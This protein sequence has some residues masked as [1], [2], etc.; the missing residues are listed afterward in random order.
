MK[1]LLSC[2]SAS[3]LAL[4]LSA[5]GGGDDDPPIQPETDPDM[6]TLPSTPDEPA[7]VPPTTM[8]D[9]PVDPEIPLP[10]DVI[11]AADDTPSPVRFELSWRS[12]GTTGTRAVQCAEMQVPLDYDNPDGE[13]ILI[14]LNRILAPSDVEHHG[15]LLYNPGGPGGSGKELARGIAGIGGFDSIAPG[16]DIIGFDPR[17][18]GDSSALEC[19]FIDAFLAGETGEEPPEDT[20][21]EMASE[22]GLEAL[23]EDWA[24]LSE[25]CRGYW[26][27]LFDH[28]GSNDVVRDIDAIRAALGEEKL[29][30]FGASYGTR[31]GALYAQTYPERVRAIVLDAPVSPRTSIV[32]HV[33]SQ[34]DETL[35]VQEAF[36]TECEAG[37]YTCPP[38][39]RALFE[40]LVTAA[41]ALGVLSPIIS[42]WELGLAY[43]SYRSYL[44]YLLEQQATQPNSDWI[45]SE[46]GRFGN[47]NGGFIQ[48]TNINCIDNAEPLL[49]IEEANARI[50]DGIARGPL[51]ASN[52]APIITCNGWNVPSDPVAP[53]TAPGAPPILVI[54]GTHDARTPTHWGVDLANSLESGVLLTSEH[55]GHTV[56]GDGDVCVDG[57]VS[58]YLVHLALPAEGTIC[59]A[60]AAALA[61]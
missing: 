20:M 19:A 42:N 23:V 25:Q 40:A 13:R 38:N 1:K 31:L 17:G 28:M 33:Q 2:A 36:F 26:G 10:T 14:A 41:D 8:D 51:F 39:S 5:C 50:T 3:W 4:T 46:V 53:L 24:W 57:T 6:E 9:E 16:F 18:V 55:W 12:C 59:R 45:Y 54:V 29:N 52:L 11:L 35:V 37:R 61:Q 49:S 30:F 15:T 58:R 48:L 32:D 27:D 56:A 7:V 22:Y 47:D 21:M 34:F 60:P 43:S 44:P